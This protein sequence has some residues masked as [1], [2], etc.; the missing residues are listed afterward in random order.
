MC[1]VRVA[2]AITSCL[3][4]RE[5]GHS[6]SIT[7]TPG[8][9]FML[10]V[11]R[12]NDL[13]QRTFQTGIIFY[14][15][16]MTSVQARYAQRDNRLETVTL[17]GFITNNG[18]IDSVNNVPPQQPVYAAINLTKSQ[19]FLIDLRSL[20]LRTDPGGT[21]IEYLLRIYMEPTKPPLYYQNFE[22]NIF[23]ELPPEVAGKWTEIEI[24]YNK[25]EAESVDENYLYSLQNVNDA[26]VIT[27]YDGTV[28]I[29][30]QNLNNR[31]ILKSVSPQLYFG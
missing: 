1:I 20:S 18:T 23:I 30:M 7:G 5:G 13:D 28:A 29:T 12:A 3:P 14:H 17:T 27:T 31:Y 11:Y 2:I 6:C 10:H 15:N 16:R 19:N 9:V 8:L 22:W 26:N 25:F 24:Y 21:G 4:E